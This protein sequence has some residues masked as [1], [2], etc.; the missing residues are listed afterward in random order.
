[1]KRVPQICDQIVSIN[2]NKEYP[3][4][5]DVSLDKIPELKRYDSFECHLV[6][7]PY[8]RKVSADDYQFNPFEEYVE[9]I[10]DDHRSAYNRIHSSASQIFGVL[11]GIVI[12]LLVYSFKPDSLFS[13][14]AIVSIFGAYALGKE[15]FG[16]IEESLRNLTKRWYVRYT[17]HYYLYQLEKFTTMT[18]YAFHAKKRRY[19]RTV[20]LPQKMDFMKQSNSQTV[21]MFFEKSDINKISTSN[22]HV[23]SIQINPALLEEFNTHGYLFGVKFSFNKHFLGFMRR[24]EIFQSKDR[25]KQGCLNEKGEWIDKAVFYRKTITFGLWKW[26]M[27]SGTF[28]DKEVIH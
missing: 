10:L 8:S 23:L 28:R 19:E 17:E 13:V 2:A 7:Y 22:A 18:N 25:K 3:H 21:R 26:F 20:L 15:L 11:L 14:E 16:D 24:F 27:K 4:I 9:D 5:L 6:I 1:M 12:F